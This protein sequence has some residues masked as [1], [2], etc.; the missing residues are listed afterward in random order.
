MTPSGFIRRAAALVILIASAAGLY[1]YYGHYT[2]PAPCSSPI[3]YHVES[4]DP[5]FGESKGDLLAA[6][7]EAANLWDDAAGRELFAY[8]P[9][10]TLSVNLLYDS[11]QQTA[12][13]GKNINKEQ[14]AYDAQKSALDALQ[15]VYEAEQQHYEAQ[16]AYWNAR[17]GAPEITYQELE[18]ERTKLN[19]EVAA[20]N[21]DAAAL[22]AMA[23][24]TN[25]K[26]NTYNAHT[27][28]DFNEGEYIVDSSGERINV[29]EFTSHAKLVRVLA[30]ELG[31]ALGL[32]HNTDKNAIMYAYNEGYAEKLTA[33][34]IA[35]LKAL[36]SLK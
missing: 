11:R 23:A 2:N 22:N 5:R 3:E 7:R 19:A 10:G 1:Y 15:A 27:G 28:T 34:D 13:L 32:E 18:A 4:L 36:C 30:H 35:E 31:H 26:V 6:I 21:A 29:Y 20:I 8:T 24:N 25:V 14:A 17:G 12:N 33:A 9:N 16:V